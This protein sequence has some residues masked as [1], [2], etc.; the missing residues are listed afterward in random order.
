MALRVLFSGSRFLV[1]LTRSDGSA[2]FAAVSAVF[3]TLCKSMGTL[4]A[5]TGC[6]QPFSSGRCLAASTGDSGSFSCFRGVLTISV[7]FAAVV[8]SVSTLGTSAWLP[9]PSATSTM[10]FAPL[11][12]RYV[13]PPSP[14]LIPAVPASFE[15]SVRLASRQIRQH[16]CMVARYT[17]ASLCGSLLYNRHDI[18]P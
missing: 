8:V 13:P 7:M 12:P 17:A 11:T 1:H 16:Y 15:V 14:W 2:S 3:P 6:L 18:L 10:C 4:D 9:T 5:S